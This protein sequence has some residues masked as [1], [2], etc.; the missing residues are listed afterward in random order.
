MQILQKECEKLKEELSSKEFIIKWTQDRVLALECECEQ[1]RHNNA[2]VLN[3]MSVSRSK[4]IELLA[5]TQQV[6]EKN[7]SLQS[8]ITSFEAKVSSEITSRSI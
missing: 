6:T 3:D 1:I 4:E 5:Y 8:K 7:V 2:E